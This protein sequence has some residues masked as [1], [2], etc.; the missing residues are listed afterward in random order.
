MTQL[1]ISAITFEYRQKDKPF[2]SKRFLF[3]PEEGAI[4]AWLNDSD[5][6]FNLFLASLTNDQQL[7]SGNASVSWNDGVRALLPIPIKGIDPA[8]GSIGDLVERIA[9]MMLVA[10]EFSDSN[11]QNNVMM[12]IA[13]RVGRLAPV[14]TAKD[15]NRVA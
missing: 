10:P 6:D 3:D 2:Q 4:S 5:R 1:L 15:P 12:R 14:K 13:D 9:Q 8:I 11:K 7:E